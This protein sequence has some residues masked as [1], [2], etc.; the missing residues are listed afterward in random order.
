MG[1]L[2]DFAFKPQHSANYQSR[3]LSSAGTLRIYLGFKLNEVTALKHS[4]IYAFIAFYPD[5]SGTGGKLRCG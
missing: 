5:A 1:A 4:S 2:S 3:N